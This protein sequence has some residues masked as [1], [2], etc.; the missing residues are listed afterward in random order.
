MK[1]KIIE[2]VIIDV[3]SSLSQASSLA[4][5]CV[6]FQALGFKGLWRIK[7]D[8]TLLS[9]AADQALKELKRLCALVSR[10]ANFS[11]A[12]HGG[13]DPIKTCRHLVSVVD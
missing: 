7:S 8:E 12:T 1:C 10:A 9:Q 5:T 13:D 2:G 6:R 11:L 4:S 3:V